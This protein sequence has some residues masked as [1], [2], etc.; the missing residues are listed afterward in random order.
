MSNA[1]SFARHGYLRVGNPAMSPTHDAGLSVRVGRETWHGAE[2]G[3]RTMSDDSTLDDLI[4]LWEQERA[5]GRELSPGDLCPGRPELVPEL[6]RH[7]EA[8]RQSY[9]LVGPDAATSSTVPG[10]SAPERAADRT[11]PPPSPPGYEVLGELGRGAM[12]VVYKARQA[13]LNRLVALKMVLSGAHAGAADLARFR[14][15]AAAI[16]RLQHPN[17]VQIHEVGQRSGHHYI[18]LE[19]V[20]GGSLAQK[21]NGMPLPPQE[22]AQL[23]QSLARATHYAH[24]Q[25]VVHRD[26]KPANILLTRDGTPKIS[27]FGLAKQ[28]AEDAGQTQSGAV[29]GTPSYMAPE[30]AEGQAKVVGPL[31]DV[32]ALGVILYEALTG[33]PPFRAPSVVETLEQVRS[34]EPVPP[35][36]LLPRVP[37]NVETICLKCLEKEPR[38]RYA[39][40]GALAEDLRRFLNEEPILAR[41]PGLVARFALWC[42]RP[43][44]IRDAGA[45]MVF[46]GTVCII[47][48]LCGLTFLAAGLLGPRD[49]RAAALQLTAFIFIFYLPL[50]CI[51]L[52][53]M[54]RR[55]FWLWVGAVVAA[56][57]VVAT[58]FGGVG[59]NPIGDALDVGGVYDNPHARYPVFSLLGILMAVQLFGYCVAL[60]AYYSNRNRLR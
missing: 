51:G 4:S 36:R 39:S 21:L 57:D 6:E 43:E 8:R 14:T 16:A 37:R 23:V 1:N 47:W 18:A 12:G 24:E 53:T 5:R 27:D 33:R 48:A 55:Q 58:V 54:A 26:L 34:Q 11:E 60:V 20:D 38:R 46:I 59:S 31:A 35:R 7:I 45:F 30:Q 44:R 40:A 19:F 10:E 42:R 49:E 2:T 56:L 13:A 29:L 32:Y 9:N 25:G 41:P 28:L 15:E 50:I 17:I 3:E 52:G 22:A